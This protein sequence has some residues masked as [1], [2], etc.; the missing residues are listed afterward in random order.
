[1]HR[2]K[3]PEHAENEFKEC[4]GKHSAS[5]PD[6]LWQSIAAFSNTRG[7][8]IFLGVN[9]AG[10][11]VGLSNPDLDKLQKDL[12][13]LST[14]TF[15]NVQPKLEIFCENQYLRVHV[16]E[17]E[18]YNKP[19]YGRKTGPRKIYIRRGATNVLAS[20]AEMRS[21]FAGNTGGG[22]EQPVE[23]SLLRLVDKNKLNDYI[24]RIGLENFR[25]AS[26]K[27]K[28]TKVKA[29]RGTKLNLFGLLAFGRDSAIDSYLKNAY[30][31]FKKFPGVNKVND[32]NPS[33]IY[34]DRIEF[35]G[36]VISQFNKAFEYVKSKLPKEAI[37][38]NKTGLR[39]ERYILPEEALREAL[40]NALAHRD[41]LIDSS[42]IN[43]DLYSDRIEL[44]NPGE[45]LVAIEDLEKSA[46]KAR[47]P[48]LMDFLKIYN[49][50]DKTARGVPTILHATR[51]RGL[52]S[53]K[54]ENISGNFKITLYFSSPH[55][56][57][58]KAWISTIS[59]NHNLKDTQ[60]NALI[61]A[62]NQGAISNKQYC[63]I[64][65]MNHRNDDRQARREL[66]A[67]VE[68]NLLVKE[69]VGPGTKYRI[70]DR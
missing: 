29:I 8:D 39:E 61:F 20:D 25:G 5:L 49:V 63:E 66:N 57:H 60:K 9:D 2:I 62:K 48:S 36:D 47:N 69:G 43:I 41:Y 31:D 56:D 23:G 53:P 6:N 7:G 38:N 40:A 28:L 54:F 3:I 33:R 11:I 4:R 44:S 68:Q 70:I 50:T 52:L 15:F 55:S 18:I 26:L 30:I 46:S 59:I 1:M 13:T 37:L 42:C 51:N 10:E 21:L 17:L 45:S 27:T 64:N 12:S 67:L 19:I 14:N 22:E 16:D 65:H 24:S 34:L 35:H 58:D 32:N